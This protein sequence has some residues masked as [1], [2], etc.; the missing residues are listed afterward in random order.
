MPV[1]PARLLVLPP[2]TS[3]DKGVAEALTLLRGVTDPGLAVSPRLF[4]TVAETV[5]EADGVAE[6]PR[7]IG[8]VMEWAGETDTARLPCPSPPAP[9]SLA[10]T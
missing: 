5:A 3:E 1:P 7:E 9:F 6:E 10:A 8:G 2:P 4:G